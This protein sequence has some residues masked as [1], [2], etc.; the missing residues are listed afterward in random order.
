MYEMNLMRSYPKTEYLSDRND[1]PRPYR[2]HASP[3]TVKAP[4]DTTTSD[5]FDDIIL[6]HVIRSFKLYLSISHNFS[7]GTRMKTKESPHH[8]LN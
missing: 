7:D 8:A 6:H 2:L 5:R 4:T 1:N 3:P